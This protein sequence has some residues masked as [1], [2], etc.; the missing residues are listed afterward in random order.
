MVVANFHGFSVSKETCPIRLDYLIRNAG[1][2]IVFTTEFPFTQCKHFLTADIGNF[3]SVFGR[4]F[5][6]CSC[7]KLQL[8]VLSSSKEIEFEFEL[9]GYEPHRTY[10]IISRQFPWF[11]WLSVSAISPKPNLFKQSAF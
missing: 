11:F 8:F 4:N 10:S 9:H 1:T 3:W 2:L 5:L 7:C 6:L